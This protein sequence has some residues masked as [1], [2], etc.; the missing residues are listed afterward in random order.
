LSQTYEYRHS[1]RLRIL[2]IAG[3]GAIVAG[4]VATS[5]PGQLGAVLGARHL[6]RPQAISFNRDPDKQGGEGPVA[7]AAQEQY[8]NRAYPNT[9]IDFAQVI[10]SQQ[11][12]QAVKQ[13][14]KGSGK[15]VASSSTGAAAAGS[16]NSS[17]W[18][19]IGPSSDRVDSFL[20][21]TPGAGAG[22]V[23]SGRVSAIAVAPDCSASNCRVWVGAAGGGIWMTSNG[24]AA[25]PSWHSSS[26]GLTS[27]SIGSIVV[28][29]ND[30]SGNTLYV[31]TGEPNGSSDSEAG[32]GLFKS[33]NG[34]ASWSLVSGSVPVSKNRSI[35]AILVDPT[36]ASHLYIGTDVARHGLSAVAGGRFTPPGAPSLGVYESSDGGTTWV[37]AL[38]PQP[39]DVVVP[40]TA[41]GAD[42]FRGGVPVLAFDPTDPTTVYAATFGFGVWRRAP[43]LE[44]GDASFMQI[45][46]PSNLSDSTGERNSLAV[47]SHTR[48]YVGQGGDKA[49][50]LWR[51]D[52]ADQ[53]AATLTGTTGRAGWQDLSSSTK[54]TP[55]YGSFNF[56]TGQCWYDQPIAS[57]AGHPDTLWIG[58]SMHY[59][60]LVP[61]SPS[62][63]RA[64]MRSTDGG[65]NFTDMTDD[66]QSPPDWLHPDQHVLAFAPNNPDIAFIGND[67]GVFRTGGTF[68]DSSGVCA[69]RGVTGADLADCQQWLSAIPT[70]LTAINGGLA[71]LQFQSLSVNPQNA[72][73]LLGGTQDNGTLSFMGSD[74]SWFET[75]N[76]DGGLS[77]TDVENSNIRVHSYF[78][79]QL[80]VNFHGVDT[81]GWDWVSDKL[82]GSREAAGF[83]VPLLADPVRSGTIFV[84]LQHVWRTQ[85]SG[86]PQAFLDAHC[87]EFGIPPFGSDQVFTGNCGDWQPIGADLTSSAFGLDKGG[88]WVAAIARPA[89][90]NA[91]WAG[92]RRGRLFISTNGNF[93]QAGAVTFTRI[94]SAAQP[95]R[96]VSGIAV[97]PKNPFHAFVSFSG[98]NAY[99]PTTPGHVFD[100][101]FDTKTGTATWVDLSHDLG[102][103][104]ITG[105]ALDSNTGDLYA[106]TDFGVVELP[107]G[108]TSWVTAGS[109]LPPVAVY[110]LTISSPSHVLYAAT[111]GRSAYRLSLP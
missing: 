59:G 12:F 96:F 34:G 93:P 17:P 40:G 98:Y 69:G 11:A 58:G 75:I 92:T 8:D 48:V 90:G 2:T 72:N 7:T 109:G 107:N 110:G 100:V 15:A 6:G 49:A 10:A 13:H 16:A 45:L 24:L 101:S 46:T 36:N 23:S 108:S 103:Q 42:F 31:G 87:N 3:L 56:C 14:T 85:D 57:P 38:N 33:T 27:N 99:T 84:G 61:N 67:G 21:Y 53:P 32:V 43:N 77:G 106:S 70:S 111:H 89:H 9:T 26:E 71:T 95:K 35:G 82:L 79:P 37:H 18:T 25:S 94:D 28:D 65:V 62:N 50:H 91:L 29:P 76:G 52:S 41:N 5:G 44:S 4:V 105:V 97:D 51:T 86:G 64:V 68:T 66:A 60:E 55:G 22:V 47:A 1:R 19:L 30:A 63:G 78:A 88:G 104:P 83:Y 73:D 54:G 81:I 80:D 102:D 39:Q 20:S 74:A